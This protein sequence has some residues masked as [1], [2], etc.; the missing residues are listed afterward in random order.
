MSRSR[1][2]RSMWPKTITR[3]GDTVTRAQMHDVFML[4]LK[5]TEKTYVRLYLLLE[6]HVGPSPVEGDPNHLPYHRVADA[7][8]QRMSANGVLE[9]RGK[10]W[11]LSDENLGL[12]A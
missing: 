1:Y 8:L 12:A 11:R 10:Q 3:K 7:M 4:W 9:H 2:S 5:G 6:K